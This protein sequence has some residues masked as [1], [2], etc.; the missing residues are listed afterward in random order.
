MFDDLMATLRKNNINALAYADDLA[1]FGIS[2][3]NLM[4]AINLVE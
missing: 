2:K 1:M 3:T 4:K